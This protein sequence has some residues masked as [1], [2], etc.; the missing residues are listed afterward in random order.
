M[1]KL[2]IIEFMDPN[3]VSTDVLRERAIHARG[4]NERQFLALIDGFEAGYL[5]YD[6][7]PPLN[8]GVLYDLLVL[9]PY[10]RCGIGSALV[11]HS[12]TLARDLG[13]RRMRLCPKA[14]DSSVSQEWLE[15]WYRRKGYGDC[16]CETELEKEL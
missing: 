12:E 16:G 8:I 5:S 3:E 1:K 4:R 2:K 6:D 7:L 9:Q 14:F 15:S 10:R 11:H 13:R